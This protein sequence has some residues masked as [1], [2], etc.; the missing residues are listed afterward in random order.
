MGSTSFPPT[1]REGDFPDIGMSRGGY[2][3]VCHGDDEPTAWAD[4]LKTINHF[5]DLL[6]Y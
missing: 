1:L 6:S 2:T 5:S 4:W 3:L